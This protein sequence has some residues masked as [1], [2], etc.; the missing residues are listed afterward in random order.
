MKLTAIHL[1]EFQSILNSS[2]FKV[3]EITCLVGKN[4]AGKTAVLQGLYRLNPIIEHEGA[5]NVTDD[6]PRWNVEDYRFEVDAKKRQPAVVVTATFE[7]EKDEID[8][9]SAIVG[10]AA[11]RNP[12]LKL[13]KG[14]G[15]T[16][17]HAIDID[18]AAALKHIATQLSSPVSSEVGNSTNIAGAVTALGKVE[19]T[20]AVKKV[21]SLLQEVSKSDGFDGY[22]Y[23]KVLSNRL[24]KL[25]YFDEYYQMTGRANIEALK[26]R[27]T[28]KTL[29]K[30]DHP[31]LG[32]I[33][34]ARLN[35]D[36][37]L[38]PTRTRELKNR[39]EG[40]GNHLTK[41]II[42]YWSQN[43]YLQMRFDVRPARPEDPIDMRSGTNIW[44]EVY[45]R[46]HMVTTELGTRSRGFVWFFSFLA[47]YGDVKQRNERL[48]LLLDE[49]GLTLHAKAQHDLLRYFEKEILGSH[50]LIYTTHSPFMVDPT[51]FERVRIVQDL[52][53]EPGATVRPGEEGTRVLSDVLEATPD[54]LFPLQG[55]L[56][57]ELH[58][59]LFVGP[60]SLVVEGV[61]DLLY[62]QTISG[63]LET[64][65]REGLNK[66]W[67]I[68]PVGGSD[69]VPTFVALIGA[70]KQLN[71]A[72]LI[73][74]Q[75]KD[76]Q[77]IENL[78][79]KKLLAKEKVLTFAEFTGTAEADIEDM[80]DVPF[81]LGLVNEEF[82]KQLARPI[83]TGDLGAGPRVLSRLDAHLAV[84][85]LRTGSFGH[86]RPARYL[87]EN[88]GRLKGTISSGTLD[89]FEAMF[90]RLNGL[91][92]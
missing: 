35:L 55:A 6:Y 22:I 57:Y 67:T 89:R 39:L 64:E 45:D 82:Q 58:Q 32:L 53:I 84:Y 2:E 40:S 66:G 16:M 80:F 24:P 47:W 63:V 11:L 9:V 23:T 69:K 50:Q 37:L 14:Y 59:T 68:T 8:A 10:P 87:S 25:L 31:L 43:Q 13:S 34:R 36:E 77:V 51:H 76:G 20:E 56:G 44:A 74:Y 86:Y 91:L 81:Y 83:T 27:E 73:D 71:V 19:Q 90:K 38:N 21:T 70:K 62:L 3:G 72:V 30:S 92:Q 15:N 49:P 42:D 12:T 88:I 5:Y 78:Y 26:K 29:L 46:Q 41:Q 4:E 1:R 33:N 18:M 60:N 48:I 52:S 85:P 65:G 7:L 75:K 17:M 54:S 79:K 28:D 61:S